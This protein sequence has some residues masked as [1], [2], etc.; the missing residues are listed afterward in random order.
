[1]KNSMQNN[2]ESKLTKEAELLNQYLSQYKYCILKKK[3][4]ENRRNE[5]IKEF[6]SPFGEVRLDGMPKKN[7]NS[8]GCAA[9][10]FQ[11]DKIDTRI[12]EQMETSMKILVNI[13][14]VVDLLPENS[15]E[16]AIIE[17]RYIDRY[18]WDRVCRENHISRTPAT[19][20]WRKGLYTLLKFK[21]VKQIIEEYR[22]EQEKDEE[23]S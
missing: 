2:T 17:N 12:K 5:I 13:M 19:K 10:S 6:S 9:I 15:I 20:N 21:K 7:S 11:L 4:L 23:A 14:N 8:V 22:N 3:T 16:R 18:N 1:M